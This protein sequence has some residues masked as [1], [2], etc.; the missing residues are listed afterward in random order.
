MLNWINSDKML[1]ISKSITIEMGE[2]EKNIIIQTKRFFALKI[3]LM[4]I[5]HHLELALKY[6]KYNQQNETIPADVILFNPL[7]S[8]IYKKVHLVLSVL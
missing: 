7:A 2:D 8:G 6:V 1:R 4:K 5:L 3:I